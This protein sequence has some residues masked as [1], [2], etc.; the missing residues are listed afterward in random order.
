MLSGIILYTLRVFPLMYLKLNVSRKSSKQKVHH[1][2]ATSSHSAIFEYSL[3]NHLLQML[4]TKVARL[5]S[6]LI[7]TFIM[8]FKSRWNMG[9]KYY[10]CQCKIK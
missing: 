2:Y 8:F 3:L 5:T 9:C 6:K 4:G 10:K 7:Q 1:I